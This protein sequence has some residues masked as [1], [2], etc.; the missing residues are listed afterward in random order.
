MKVKCP[1]CHKEM[2]WEQNP[3]RPFC[4]KRC[5]LI[6]LG[7][8]ATERYRVPGDK[9][10]SE[11]DQSASGGEEREDESSNNGKKAS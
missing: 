6:D 5:K 9:S 3:Y 1:I 7:Q 4:S 2:E 10:L 8:W 11:V